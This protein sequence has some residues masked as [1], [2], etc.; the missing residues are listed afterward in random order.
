MAGAKMQRFMQMVQNRAY[1]A[2]S[3]LLIKDDAEKEK[4]IGLQDCI[5]IVIHKQ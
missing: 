4:I 2:T 1:K 3:S 5:Q